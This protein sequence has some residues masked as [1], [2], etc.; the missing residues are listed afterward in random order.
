MIECKHVLGS[1][2]IDLTDWSF[3]TEPHGDRDDKCLG[4]AVTQVIREEFKRDP[5]WLDLPSL[6]ESWVGNALT[7]DVWLPL[8]K[9]QDHIVKYRATLDEIISEELTN[10]ENMMHIADELDRLAQK[11][12]DHQP[13]RF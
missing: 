6:S 13:V 8:G 12:R 11:I 9:D 7:L 4:A 2:E 10:G 5:P 3:Y 1:D